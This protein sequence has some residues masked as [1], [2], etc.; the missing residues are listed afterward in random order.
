MSFTVVPLNNI[1]IPTGSHIPFGDKFVLQD[2]PD[3]LK[4]DQNYLKDLSRDERELVF[5]G[6]TCPRI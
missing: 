5:S 1:D 6:K 2:V 3:W 4:Q